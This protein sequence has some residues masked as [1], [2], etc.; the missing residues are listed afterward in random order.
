MQSWELIVL[1]LSKCAMNNPNTRGVEDST[2]VLR[3]Q[4]VL[5]QVTEMIRTAH[6]GKD[7]KNL[8]FV[9]RFYFYP[10]Y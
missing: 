8:L 9:H 3:S 1:L 7:R 5:S 10:I 2:G 6:F 4:R